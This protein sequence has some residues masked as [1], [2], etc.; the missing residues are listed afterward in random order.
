M[1]ELKE[2]ERLRE[3]MEKGESYIA[4]NPDDENAAS[5]Y[6]RLTEKYVELSVAREDNTAVTLEL[7]PNVTWRRREELPELSIVKVL[8]HT[9]PQADDEMSIADLA[10]LNGAMVLMPKR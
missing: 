7:P 5:L 10:E 4:A 8:T 2:L 3:R 9:E 6:W 1:P